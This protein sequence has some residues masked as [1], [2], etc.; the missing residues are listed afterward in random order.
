MCNIW[1]YIVIQKIIYL[2]NST[3]V[4]DPLYIGLKK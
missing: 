4:R 1:K 2:K 3:V